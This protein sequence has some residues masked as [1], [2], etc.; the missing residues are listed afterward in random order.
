MIQLIVLPASSS[1]RSPLQS[2][3]MHFSRSTSNSPSSSIRRACCRLSVVD[4]EEGVSKSS[5]I[6]ALETPHSLIRSEHPHLDAAVHRASFLGV[7]G[8]DR[9]RGAVAGDLDPFGTDA[10]ADQ[11]GLHRL[12]PL[13]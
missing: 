11:I 9:L 10:V 5:M 6:S 1:M 2:F 12:G 8:G 3:Q 7:V 13:L 4:C